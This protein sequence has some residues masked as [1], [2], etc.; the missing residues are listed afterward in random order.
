MLKASK[1]FET[2]IEEVASEEVVAEM[3]M[4]EYL[5]LLNLDSLLICLHI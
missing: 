5:S 4:A 1:A 3:P 2:V